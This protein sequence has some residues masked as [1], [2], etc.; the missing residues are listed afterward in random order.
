MTRIIYA[1][2]ADLG[3]GAA[4][5]V[6]ILRMCGAL[7]EQRAE[8]QLVVRRSPPWERVAADF[9]LTRPFE[10]RSSPSCAGRLAAAQFATAVVRVSRPG[11]LVLT[12]DL[13]AA[14]L[15][16]MA[17]RA[18]I[19]ETHAPFNAGRSRFMFRLLLRLKQFLGL[20]VITRALESHFLEEFGE[21]LIGRTVVLPDGAIERATPGSKTKEIER[22]AVGYLGTFLPGKGVDLVLR[23]AQA[24]PEAHFHLVGGTAAD[25]GLSSEAVPIN[26][27]F[28]GRVPHS[29][30]IE[31]IDS[32]DIALLPNSN[33]VLGADRKV[34]IGRWT[35]PL[36]LF[37]YMA[38]GR[39]IIASRIPVLQEV[40]E[41]GR[42]C[43]LADPEDPSEWTRSIRLLLDDPDRA[44]R[45]GRQ[46][47]EDL[48]QKYT[49][50]RRAKRMIDFANRPPDAAG[51]VR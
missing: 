18:V 32:F 10:I 51:A 22:P 4:H 17:G 30:T 26:V 25:A 19:F 48:E 49:W 6:H 7:A 13:P 23:I 12:R 40:L 35:S 39:P 36:K 50:R 38:A 8:V 34:D 9:G 11:D 46:A 43:L 2:G 45:M 16:A 44:A 42:N 47:R 28:A 33:R 29:E 1:A 27:H 41:D 21:P 24:M 3:S 37:E 14:L 20:V 31:W 5:N 15:A